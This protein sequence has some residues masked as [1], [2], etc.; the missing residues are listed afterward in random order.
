MRI[1]PIQQTQQN[2]R[3]NNFKGT[4]SPEVTQLIDRCAREEAERFVFHLKKGESVN[5]DALLKIKSSWDAVSQTLKKKLELIHPNTVMKVEKI[6][7]HS[8]I[9]YKLIF[10]N[11][12]VGATACQ[13]SVYDATSGLEV[14]L[15]T[16]EEFRRVVDYISPSKVNE[17]IL[18]RAI[19]NIEIASCN[20]EVLRRTNISTD[21]Y[22]EIIKYQ[23]QIGTIS[24]EESE[25]NVARLDKALEEARAKRTEETKI[26]EA[27]QNNLKSLDEIFGAKIE[28]VTDKQYKPLLNLTP[29][30]QE[31]A[32]E[33]ANKLRK[34]KAK[35]SYWAKVMNIF[36]L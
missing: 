14:G 29:D 18:E 19:R 28:P 3:N 24:K 6:L 8:G 4:I 15:P 36:G 12:S 1:N 35:Y 22:N 16:S 5:Q 13:A 31:Y 7:R 9:K 26:A 27:E 17:T 33:Q 10:E 11:K 30:E 34:I 2:Y 25:E 23:N 21:R 32:T 20:K